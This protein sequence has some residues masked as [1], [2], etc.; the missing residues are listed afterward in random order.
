[1]CDAAGGDVT[2]RGRRSR[3]LA[4]LRAA[5]LPLAHCGTA[6]G[7]TGTADQRLQKLHTHLLRSTWSRR[8]RLL[9]SRDSNRSRLHIGRSGRKGVQRREQ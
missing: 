8:Q 9:R 5:A 7:G 4:G 2:A 3:S 1:M 6:S